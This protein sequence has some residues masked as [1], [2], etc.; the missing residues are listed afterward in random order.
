M[1]GSIR[2]RSQPKRSS[3]GH[4]RSN[5]CTAAVRTPSDVR[6]TT[7]FN[8]SAT[9]KWPMNMAR[10]CCV[11]LAVV[12]QVCRT[13]GRRAGSQCVPFRCHLRIR[14]GRPPNLTWTPARRCNHLPWS[15]SR[16]SVGPTPTQFAR[17]TGT[18]RC[19]T[20]LSVAQ[21]PPVLH[22][23]HADCHLGRWAFTLLTNHHGAP[24]GVW[25]DAP[26]IP[27]RLAISGR[28]IVVSMTGEN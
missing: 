13:A 1:P 11:L 23:V 6:G 9:A 24:F 22:Q 10:H 4:S 16:C 15:S 8:A 7:G 20:T 3:T 12:P 21:P 25:V 19:A 27:C 5:H 26:G 17:A 28:E 18:P 14:E 2:T